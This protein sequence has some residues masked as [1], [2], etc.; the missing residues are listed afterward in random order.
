MPK[1]DE[2]LPDRKIEYKKERQTEVNLEVPPDLTKR[3]IDDTR[4]VPDITSPGSATYSD[5]VGER[6]P[7]GG[8]G[9]ASGSRRGAEVLPQIDKIT[10][11]RDGDQR[12]LVVQAPVEDVWFKVLSFWQEG[13]ILLL[14]QDPS[15]GVMRTNWIEN[16]A[17]IKSDFLT[18]TIRMAFDGLY[19]AATR[20]QYRVRLEEGDQPGFTE[21]FLTHR[22]MEE[23]LLSGTGSDTEQAAW[24]IRPTDHG[25][26]AEMLRRMM[27][28]L[29]VKDKR[30]S[31][32]LAQKD[33]RERRSQ[34]VRSRNHSELKIDED[35]SR[36]WRI[37][38]MALDR[39]GFA[40]EDRDRGKG[41]YYVRYNDPMAEQ[42]EKGI[43]SKLMFWDSD[44]K[45]DKETQYQV[46]LRAEDKF[47]RVAIL[48]S[49]GKQDNSETARRILTLLHEQIK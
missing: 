7:A 45:I 10:V 28:F 31:S 8:A 42:E 3:S 16:R 14:E 49:K 23:K 19:S 20:D 43:L 21:V 24:V 5:Y 41:I 44:E 32:E 40:V 37:T 26:E 35:F 17:D 30:A 38:G 48:D 18:E 9:T 25:L 22:G 39:G 15:V 29:G 46:S 27:V 34:L 11:K 6:R 4:L 47:T 12:W 2:V 33:S 36:A 13:G 1:V